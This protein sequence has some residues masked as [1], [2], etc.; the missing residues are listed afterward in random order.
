MRAR[1]LDISSFALKTGLPAS[2]LAQPFPQ[3]CGKLN[4]FKLL[5]LINKVS[6]LYLHLIFTRLLFHSTDEFTYIKELREELYDMFNY[7]TLSRQ[8][9]TFQERTK[10]FIDS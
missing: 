3:S 10:G 7:R 2:Q 5:Y 4:T 8:T 6:F 1:V 9:K